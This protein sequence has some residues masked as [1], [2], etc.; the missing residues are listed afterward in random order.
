MGTRK[1]LLSQIVEKEVNHTGDIGD[2]VNIFD[3][4]YRVVSV[5][6]LEDFLENIHT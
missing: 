1:Y 2:W 5:K 4:G 3:K 6:T